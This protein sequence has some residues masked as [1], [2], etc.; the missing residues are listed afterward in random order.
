MQAPS[1]KRKGKEEKE[2]PR[3]LR[4]MGLFALEPIARLEINTY[5]RFRILAGIFSFFLL[6]RENQR[7]KN[8]LTDY[9]Q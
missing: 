9:R 7:R 5:N 2:K 1:E 6:R 8:G 4:T 3:G